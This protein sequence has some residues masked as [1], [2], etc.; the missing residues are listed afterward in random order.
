M[1]PILEKQLQELADC[2]QQR[3]DTIADTRFAKHD[4]VAHLDKLKQTSEAVF[5]LQQDLAGK[6]PARLQ[7]F[8]EQ[9]SYNKALAF[10]R[11]M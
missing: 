1:D 3:L 7:H 9:C 8:L 5:E 2:L 11:G 6:I 4:P 10:I